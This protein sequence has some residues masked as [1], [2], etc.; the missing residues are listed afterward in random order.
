MSWRFRLGEY[1]YD[2]ENR[3]IV[4]TSIK[5]VYDV[6]LVSIPAN[7][8]TYINARACV[9]GEIARAA[10]REAELDEQRRR[11]R[12]KIMNCIGGK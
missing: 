11:L 2:A 7:D 8:N 10:L 3:T 5:K 6:S 1:Y 4:H 9:D 12:I